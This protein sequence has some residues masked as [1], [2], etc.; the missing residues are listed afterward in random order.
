MK[1]TFTARGDG[2]ARARRKPGYAIG[3]ACGDAAARTIHRAALHESA[4]RKR[5]G[6]GWRMDLHYDFGPDPANP[7][8]RRMEQLEL[9]LGCFQKALGH[10][11]PNQLVAHAGPGPPAWSMEQGDRLDDEGR[12]LLLR[13]ADLARRTD[14]LVRTLAE[15]G[16]LTARPRAG[17]GRVA[18]GRGARGGRRGEFA[19]FRVVDRVPFSSGGFGPPRSRRSLRLVLVHLIRNAVQAGGGRTAPLEVGSR[20]TPEGVEW[21][22]KDDGRGFSET[23]QAAPVRVLR[24]RRR[25]GT[26]PGPPA[27]GRVGRR[28]P[29]P[30]RTRPGADV[31]PLVRT[32]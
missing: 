9:L 15:I 25:A 4:G 30:L 5:P 26:V 29:R 23:Q 32:A 17:R 28:R 13:L 22:V 27:R 21:W 16:R 14:G 1:H 11:L 31:H 7:A 6:A 12:A 10:E 20:R 2:K 19:V 3:L 8:R 24:R 18:A